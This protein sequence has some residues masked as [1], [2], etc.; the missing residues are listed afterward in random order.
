[1]IIANSVFISFAAYEAFVGS[2]LN[3][4]ESKRATTKRLVTY[5]NSNGEE[6][7]KDCAS[8]DS[9]IKEGNCNY[10]D[11]MT[12]PEFEDHFWLWS[13]MVIVQEAVSY[14]NA[15]TM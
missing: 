11:I 9:I 2:S 8:N 6:Q 5:T 12:M 15:G 14:A 4:S 3:S 10:Q 1:M 7:Y 13:L